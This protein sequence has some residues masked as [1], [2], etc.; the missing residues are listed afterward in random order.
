MRLMLLALLIASCAGIAIAAQTAPPVT[1]RVGKLIDGRGGSLQ[2]VV[3]TVRDG[4]IASV[5]NSKEAV[6][7]DLSK[8]TL[9]PGFIDMHVHILWHFGAD[10]R[11]VG[12]PESP[13]TRLQAGGAN[14]R[15]TIEHGFTTVQSVGETL[16]ADLRAR[17]QKDALPGPRILTSRGQINEHSGAARVGGAGAL[18]T[19]EQLR[20]AVR[21]LKDAGADLIKIF[22]SAS[23]RDGGKQTMSDE[24]LQAAC[25]EARALG[26]RTL[27]H[28]HSPESIKASVLA[29]CTQIEH[30]NFAT[31][32]SLKLMAEHGTYFDPNVGLVLQNY[33]E[34][35]AKFL[36]IGNYTE[37]GFAAMEKSLPVVIDMFKRAVNTP[38]LKIVYG[39]DAVAGAH[40]RNIEEAIVRVQQGG[41]QPM[42]AIVSLTSR[43]AGGLR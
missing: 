2:N 24:Q 26:L 6:T 4:K 11:Y 23:I 1:I 33:L 39:T 29:G 31:D 3:V 8:Y 28:A 9:L 18:A 12:S 41:Q 34:N 7:H 21:D 42:D 20:K 10:G 5:G 15:T 25:G 22:A 35:K 13:E 14:A 30:G 32:E 43:S 40:G 37:E 19:A 17:L 16:D 36:G 27:V 38:G